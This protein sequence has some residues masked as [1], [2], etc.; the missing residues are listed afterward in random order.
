VATGYG[1]E[2]R[3]KSASRFREPASGEVRAQR[4]VPAA[5]APARPRRGGLDE[6]EVPEFIPNL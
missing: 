4:N 2:G 1:E 5:G 3:R 6:L